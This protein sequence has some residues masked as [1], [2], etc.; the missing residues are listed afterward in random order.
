MP[1]HHLEVVRE[2]LLENL[3]KGFIGPSYAP[4]ASPILLAEKH[5]KTR[6]CVDFRRLNALTKKDKYPLPLI[7]ELLERLSK[8]KV[9][10]K[11][12][13]R[14]GF[15]RIRMDPNSKNLTTFRTQYGQFKYRV[16][17]FGVLNGPAIF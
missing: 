3:D 13:I 5:G 11:L 1:L 17:P 6:F 14:Q 7:D 15:Y 12:D 2:Y 8:A 9:F 4:F 16:M 10:T